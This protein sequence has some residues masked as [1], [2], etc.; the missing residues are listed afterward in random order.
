RA[1][2]R[3]VFSAVTEQ[4]CGLD[5]QADPEVIV[6]N[7][8]TGVLRCSFKS[9]EV[10]TKRTTVTWKFQSNQPNSL[11]LTIF[12]FSDGQGYPGLEEFKERV[13]FIGDINKRD[14][15]IQ[16]SPTQFSDNGT[17]I[18]D[19]KNPP[20]VSGTQ[21]E[22]LLR[23]VLK[24]SLPQKNTGVIVAAVCGAMVLLVIIAVAAC[25]IMRV[26]HSRHEYEG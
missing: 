9:S 2:R 23:V 15:S 7:G 25:I 20:D 1:A 19:V 10:V 6:Q 24:E 26:L 3:D 11:Y 4:T 18:C 17:F 14:V 5:V 21:A 8:T 22:T 12:Y 16:L 13:Q